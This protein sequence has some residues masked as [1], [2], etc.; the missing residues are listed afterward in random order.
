LFL[1]NLFTIASLAICAAGITKAGSIPPD[2]LENP[3]FQHF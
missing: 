2:P 3:G 1:R